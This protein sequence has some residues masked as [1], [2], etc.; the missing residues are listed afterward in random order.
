MTRPAG[1]RIETEMKAPEREGRIG[2]VVGVFIGIMSGAIL[3][4]VLSAVATVGYI[5]AG[6][7]RFL[8]RFGSLGALYA[9]YMLGCLQAGLIGGMLL[10]F[11]K[12][13]IG[14]FAVGMIAMMPLALMGGRF[15]FG[16][17]ANWEPSQWVITIGWAI[18]VGGIGGA[19]FWKRLRQDLR[20][21]DFPA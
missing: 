6:S 11:A 3:G 16:V 8:N 9:V 19:V 4:L 17:R 21:D 5:F 7:E 13:C 2:Y 1:V 20:K 14:A 15:V 10:R 18:L 12:Y